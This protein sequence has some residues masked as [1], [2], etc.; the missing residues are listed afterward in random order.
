MVCFDYLLIVYLSSFDT[1]PYMA[2]QAHHIQHAERAVPV[3]A[4]HQGV[5]GHHLLGRDREFGVRDVAGV[6]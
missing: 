5:G 6:A 1:G 4:R 2:A 3:V